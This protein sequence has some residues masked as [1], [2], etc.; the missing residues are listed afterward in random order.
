V[1]EVARR[2]RAKSWE[3]RAA[4]CLARLLARKAAAIR[5][6]VARGHL[7]LVHRR[8]RHRRPK[9]RRRRCLRSWTPR[10]EGFPRRGESF[11]ARSLA[12]KLKQ[13]VGCRQQQMEL[14]NGSRL[15]VT[16]PVTFRI[17]WRRSFSAIW[18]TQR[19]VS[20]TPKGFILT[21]MCAV[22]TGSGKPAQRPTETP[23]DGDPACRKGERRNTDRLP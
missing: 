6:H 3:L 1:I 10:L 22:R 13:A 8:L 21:S 12:E 4:T 7:Q 20:R 9:G 2:Q 5:P 11:P 17:I 14:A 19:P 16:A 18:R 23:P 15:T